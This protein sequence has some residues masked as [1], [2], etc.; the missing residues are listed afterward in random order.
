[1]YKNNS[2][3]SSKFKGYSPLHRKLKDLSSEIGYYSYPKR[4]HTLKNI[5]KKTQALLLIFISLTL[6]NCKYDANKSYSINGKIQGNLHNYI[7][8]EIN[9]KIDSTLII[10]NT[11]EFKGNVI[12]PLKANLM[13]A[14]PK[15]S[16]GF[17]VIP[18]MLENSEIFIKL[19]YSEKEFRGMNMKLLKMD[20]ISGSKSQELMMNFDL[21]MEN[22]FYKEESDSIREIILYNN[23]LEFIEVNPKSILSGEKLAS[24]SNFYGYLNSSQ[25]EYLYKLI[26]TNYQSKKDLIYID[27]IIKRRKILDIGN[28]PPRIILPNQNGELIDNESLKGN[29]VLLEFWASWCGP[30]RKTN[31]ELIKIYNSF[32]DKDFEIFGISQDKDDNKWKN[33]IKEDKIEWIQV[34]DSLNTIGDQY[35]LTTIPFNLLLNREGKIIERNIKPSKL[36][37]FLTD[38]LK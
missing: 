20:S 3:D 37:A 33:A 14:N 30:C 1:M 12:N 23:L 19:N 22:T 28:I 11:F 9:K 26:D 24:L 15:L 31:P 32:K 25:M 17:S 21:K 6:T 7:Y 38:R 16:D 34:I 5:M 18:F 10:D 2:R 29:F 36:N 35:H 4:Y 27:N 8:L 13:P